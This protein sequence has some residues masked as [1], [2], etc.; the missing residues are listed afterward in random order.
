MKSPY[1]VQYSHDGHMWFDLSGRGTDPSF[2]T[3]EEANVWYDRLLGYVGLLTFIRI[4]DGDGK[5]IQGG[6]IKDA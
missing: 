5:V 4:I 1:R 3:L 6:E 2:L